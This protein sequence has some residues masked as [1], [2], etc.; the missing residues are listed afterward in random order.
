MRNKPHLCQVF[1][2]Q[3]KAA[4]VMVISLVTLIEP[5]I[6]DPFVTAPRLIE[7][8]DLPELTDLF[9]HAHADGTSDPDSAKAAASIL[10]LIHI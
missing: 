7:A 3:G 4:H 8:A 5:Q 1:R 2:H 6:L 9:L 10:S